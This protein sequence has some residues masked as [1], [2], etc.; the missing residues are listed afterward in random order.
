[1]QECTRR[2]MYCLSVPYSNAYLDMIE[3]TSLL[4]PVYHMHALYR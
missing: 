2:K 3:T 4:I 1:M